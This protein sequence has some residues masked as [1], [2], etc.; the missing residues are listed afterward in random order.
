M[1]QIVVVVRVTGQDDVAGYLTERCDSLFLKARVEVAATANLTAALLPGDSSASESLHAAVAHGH[2]AMVEILLQDSPVSTDATLALETAVN[3]HRLHIIRMIMHRGN[4]F[5]TARVFRAAV[6]TRQVE[7]VDL[8]M[9]ESDSVSVNA[10]LIEALNRG[11]ASIVTFLLKRGQSDESE[12]ILMKEAFK[13]RRQSVQQL[14][15]SWVI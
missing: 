2:A 4:P 14:L 15:A 9:P 12:F 3:Q 13:G 8:L 6:A 11:C 1:V 5:D 10:A 7:V